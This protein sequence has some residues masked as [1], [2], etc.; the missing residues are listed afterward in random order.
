M[1]LHTQP[2]GTL[3]VRTSHE[4][5]TVQQYCPAVP[6]FHPCSGCGYSTVLYSRLQY[7]VLFASQQAQPP[8]RV[9]NTCN[10]LFAFIHLAVGCVVCFKLVLSSIVRPPTL[11]GVLRTP[12][13]AG[14]RTNQ[15]GFYIVRV[16]GIVRIN[17]RDTYPHYIRPPLLYY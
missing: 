7:A 15:A 12:N 14:K 2:V 11:L 13:S 10:T 9:G 5:S 16:P 8:I 4:P 3:R 6:S 17:F 1:T